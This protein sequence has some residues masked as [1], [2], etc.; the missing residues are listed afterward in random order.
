MT[1]QFRKGNISRAKLTPV[2]VQDIRER[3]AQGATQGALA[4]EFRVSIGQI[5]RITR[6]EA[7]L[8]YG[9]RPEALGSQAHRE[10]TLPS[11]SVIEASQDRLASLLQQTA[12]ANDRA[13]ERLQDAIA[14]KR[15]DGS[16]LEDLLK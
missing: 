4:R 7:W 9:E 5:G 11:E 6:G 12:E 14:E 16:D 2:Q 1:T 8:D 10:A 13:L 15:K 3:F